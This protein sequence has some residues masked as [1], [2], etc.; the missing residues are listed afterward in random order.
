MR[1]QSLVINDNPLVQSASLA[2]TQYD[3]LPR[4]CESAWNVIYCLP[5][6]LLLPNKPGVGGTSCFTFIVHCGEEFEVMEFSSRL[7][8][9]L[10][11]QHVFKHV[12]VEFC[13]LPRSHLD[14]FEQNPL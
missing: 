10:L 3:H 14:L 9:W 4:L 12:Y 8:A 13:C 7:S 5:L 6:L 2:L 11:F 1:N